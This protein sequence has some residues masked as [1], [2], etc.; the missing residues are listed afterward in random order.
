MIEHESARTTHAARLFAGLGRRYDR[1]GALLSFGQ[2]RRWRRFLVSRISER[3]PLVLDVA[4]GT[5]LVAEEL[6]RAQRAER[7]I[8]LDRSEPMLRSGA[9]VE[10]A[11]L[12]LG[13][14]ESL[15]FADATFDA[16]TVTYLFRYVDDPGETLGEL[17]RV[18]RPGGVVASLEF[19]VP[20][21]AGWR[22]AWRLYTRLAMPVIG[23]TASRDWFEVG[24]FL[25]PSIEEYWRR[26][27]L[28]V[29]ANLWHQ[30]GLWPIGW[31][32]MS[33]GGGVVTW[34]ARES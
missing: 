15:P 19:G 11:E 6:R 12:V 33:L 29:Q 20:Q 30:A 9:R 23:A 5:G 4:T 16:L 18:V 22:A 14:A 24:R 7:V 25:G 3:S 1:M 28:A 26:Y 21:G 32:R 13:R 17:A 10:T 2:D 27:P 31:R 8:G 34:G